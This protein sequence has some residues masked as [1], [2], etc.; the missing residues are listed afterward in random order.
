MRD[1][2][3]TAVGLGRIIDWPSHSAILSKTK[4]HLTKMVLSVKSSIQFKFKDV[5]LLK[6]K[7]KLTICVGQDRAG[8]RRARCE[9]AR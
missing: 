2:K 5:V 1:R 4:D 9:R 8:V 3:K 7:K 6:S